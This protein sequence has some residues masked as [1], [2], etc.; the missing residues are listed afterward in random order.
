M[1][2][3]P[4]TS[5]GDVVGSA[6]HPHY[7]GFTGTTPLERRLLWQGTRD[8]S[9]FLAVP[10]AIEFLARHAGPEVRTR[11]RTMARETLDRAC[12]SLGVRPIAGSSEDHAQ[13]VVIPVPHTDPVAL[14]ASI[15]DGHRIEVPVTS[16]AGR[17]FVRPSVAAYTRAQ[18][19][20]ALLAL[21]PTLRAQR[22]E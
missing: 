13:M 8:I 12:A 6:P 19:L 7:D 3:A 16:H 10:A 2:Q 17:C 20:Q 22:P 4:I 21:L 5:W 9:A 14:R 1:L 18:E 11:C 15:Y